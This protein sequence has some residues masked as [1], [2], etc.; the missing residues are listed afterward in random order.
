[1]DVSPNPNKQE[2]QTDSLFSLLVEMRDSVMKQDFDQIMVLDRRFSSE[3]D[4]IFP[5]TL[6]GGLDTMYD[7]C[8]NNYVMS[9]GN[10]TLYRL[11]V[12]RERFLDCAESLFSEIVR[13]EGR[14]IPSNF[15]PE[16]SQ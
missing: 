2:R 7:G 1:M 5:L 6:S 10:E 4:S 9:S 12:P 15:V 13:C 14:S 3:F 11:G 8:R 16:Y